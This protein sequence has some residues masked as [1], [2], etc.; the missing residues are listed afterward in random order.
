MSKDFCQENALRL[1]VEETFLFVI[2]YIVFRKNTSF[3]LKHFRRN[4]SLTGYRYIFACKQI[5]MC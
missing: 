5:K 3:F 2:K 4:A 1:K